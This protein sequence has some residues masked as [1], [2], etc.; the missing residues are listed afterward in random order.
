MREQNSPAQFIPYNLPPQPTQQS[1]D[2]DEYRQFISLMRIIRPPPMSFISISP[3]IS[4]VRLIRLSGEE[5][6]GN[7]VD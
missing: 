1:N 6:Q 5:P 3:T 7:P 2:E 4:F